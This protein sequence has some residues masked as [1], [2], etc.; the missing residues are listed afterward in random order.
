MKI[1][2]SPSINGRKAKKKSYVGEKRAILRREEI[3]TVL[4]NEE[5][6]SLLSNIKGEWMHSDDESIFKKYLVIHGVTLSCIVKSRKRF[7]VID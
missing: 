6:I 2:L 4:I 7:Y 3:F 5:C 1:F